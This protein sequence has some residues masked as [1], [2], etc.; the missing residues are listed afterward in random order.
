MYVFVCLYMYLYVFVGYCVIMYYHTQV[1]FGKQRVG[2]MHCAD[3]AVK[4][5]INVLSR[6]VGG[7]TKR[8]EKLSVR[9]ACEEHSIFPFLFANDKKN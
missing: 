2:R 5:I 7:H 4:D 3:H 1:I 6:S 9:I 8:S